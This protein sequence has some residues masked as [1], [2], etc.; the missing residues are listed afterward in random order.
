V[1]VVCE[2]E[3][4]GGSGQLKVVR[5]LCGESRTSREQQRGGPLKGREELGAAVWWY[6]LLGGRVGEGAAP[7]SLEALWWSWKQGSQHFRRDKQG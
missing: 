4:R 1:V 6:C 2:W 3:L 7:A 5:C